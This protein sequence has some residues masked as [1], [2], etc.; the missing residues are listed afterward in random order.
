V[1]LPLLLVDSSSDE[2]IAGH[3]FFGAEIRKKCHWPVFGYL[4]VFELDYQIHDFVE[5]AELPSCRK[6]S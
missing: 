4:S 5:V 6:S 3:R 2:L 1:L